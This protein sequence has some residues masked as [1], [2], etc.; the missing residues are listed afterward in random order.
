MVVVPHPLQ[1]LSKD[2][3]CL[4]RD[5]LVQC[6]PDVIIEFR[7]IGLQEP[8]KAE[9]CVFLDLEHKG[10]VSSTTPRPPRLAKCHYDTIGSDKVPQYHESV[11]DLGQQSRIEHQ[12][13]SQDISPSLTM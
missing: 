6:H 9:L 12:V 4:A 1:H 7:E 11:I 8:P 13:V 3:T 10:A 5:I 2:E